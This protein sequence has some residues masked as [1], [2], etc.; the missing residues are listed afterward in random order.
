LGEAKLGDRAAASERLERLIEKQT[1]LGIKGLSIGLSTEAR[2]RIAIW[3]REP[4]QF[5][6]YAS[7]TAREYRHGADSPLGGRY[8]RLIQEA[9]RHGMQTDVQL[10]DFLTSTVLEDG[11]TLL[12]DVHGAVLRAMHGAQDAE[13]RAVRALRLL[14]ETRGSGTGHLF[15]NRREGFKLVASHPAAAPPEGLCVLAQEF[16]LK[17]QQRTDMISDIV[18]GGLEEEGLQLPIARVDGATYELT[19][20]SCAVAGSARV[21]GVAAVMPGSEPVGNA[22]QALLLS[23]L[24][25]HFVQAGDVG[26]E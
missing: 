3:A 24:A 2:A 5:E 13:D 14:C 1:A 22:S 17:Q 16:L 26:R 8:E 20:L 10:S 21:A 25:T 15:L 6:R 9:T 7:L 11:T 19:L 18:T 12:H 4:Q 23:T